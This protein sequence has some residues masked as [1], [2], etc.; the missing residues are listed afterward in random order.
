MNKKVSIIVVA[1]VLILIGVYFIFFN[2]ED[3]SVDQTAN[4]DSTATTTDSEGQLDAASESDAEAELNT[5][6][7]NPQA[8]NTVFVEDKTAA[9]TNKNPNTTADA[10]GSAA[11]KT[12]TSANS[13]FSFEYKSGASGYTVIEAPAQELTGT[14][15]VP[16]AVVKT[17]E[18]NSSPDSATG[19]INILT[20][21]DKTYA[22]TLDWVKDDVRT[23]FP[24]R[25]ESETY[26]TITVDG[27]TA[28]RY[29]SP[30]RP[31]MVG[32]EPYKLPD[33]SI[34]Y[35]EAKDTVA[36][37]HGNMGTTFTLIY[38]DANDPI[39]ADFEAFLKSIQFN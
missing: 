4:V 14:T 36:V 19:Y 6:E 28:I 39:R 37:L 13:G 20:Y 17:S 38:K 9:N 7:A 33:G 31:M 29:S 1:I 5:D 11:T 26:Q 2:S 22:S 34:Y 27:V 21:D 25:T 10:S 15:V 16:I 24:Q 12:H 8:S 35:L 23:N 3:A 30:R 18:V 32:D